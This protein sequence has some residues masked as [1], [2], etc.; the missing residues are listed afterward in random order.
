MKRRTNQRQRQRRPPGVRHK[1]GA[2]MKSQFLITSL[3]TSSPNHISIMH[4]SPNPILRRVPYANIGL[5]QPFTPNF[6]K[7]HFSDAWDKLD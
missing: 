1:S 3:E 5:Y 6:G 2:G 4:L 7:L